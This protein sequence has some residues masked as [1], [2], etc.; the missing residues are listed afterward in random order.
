LALLAVERCDQIYESLV[1]QHQSRLI[2]H[3]NY[4]HYFHDDSFQSEGNRDRLGSASGKDV[5]PMTDFMTVYDNAITLD[6][7]G[8][9]LSRLGNSLEKS[10]V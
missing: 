9:I 3:F 1:G 10:R 6:L 2:A 8:E 7:C 5:S 4:F